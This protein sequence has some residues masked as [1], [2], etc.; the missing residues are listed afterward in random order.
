MFVLIRATV[1]ATLF[2]SLLL[3]FVP[4]QLLSWAGISRP[5]TIGAPQIAGSIVGTL[6]G[7]LALWCVLTFAVAGKG[8]PAPFDPPRRLVVSGP[9]RFVR[10]PM[11]LGAALAVAGAALFYQSVELLAYASVFILFSHVFVVYYEEPALRRTFGDEYDN[12]SQ[13]VRRWG[14]SRTGGRLR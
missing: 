2:I 13:R 12:Y 3:V 7:L 11:Y 14:P 9:Y 10:N 5:T 1:Y 4:A 6:G 8:T